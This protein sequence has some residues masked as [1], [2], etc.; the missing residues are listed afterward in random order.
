[1]TAQRTS[2]NSITS[3]FA[4]TRPTAVFRNFSKPLILRLCFILGGGSVCVE[5]FID[6]WE[7]LDIQSGY[8]KKSIE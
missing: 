7:K 5:I 8:S 3:Q 1:M 4:V 2:V 6:L